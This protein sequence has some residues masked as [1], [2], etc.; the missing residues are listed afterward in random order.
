MLKHPSCMNVNRTRGIVAMFQS[1]R[2][3]RWLQIFYQLFSLLL[4]CKESFGWILPKTEFIGDISTVQSCL[5]KWEKIVN[6]G[7]GVAEIARKS[8][9]ESKDKRCDGGRRKIEFR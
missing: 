6:F 7:N 2:Y 1:K 4:W 8:M 9:R 5:E 3:H